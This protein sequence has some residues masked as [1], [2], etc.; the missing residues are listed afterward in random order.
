MNDKYEAAA[1]TSKLT[2]SIGL[3]VVAAHQ[4][5]H[6]VDHIRADGCL[7]HCGEAD[8]LL[9]DSFILFRVHGD[10]WPGVA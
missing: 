6:L 1:L 2:D 10:Q 9:L 4:L 7:E 3:T 5:V 8:V